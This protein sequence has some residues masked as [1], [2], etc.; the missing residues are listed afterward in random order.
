MLAQEKVG[1]E[2]E[3]LRY[4]QA[5]QNLQHLTSLRPH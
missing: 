5:L 1:G 4:C 3:E 2:A